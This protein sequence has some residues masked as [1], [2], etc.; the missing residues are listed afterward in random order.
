[1]TSAITLPLEL[2]Y[3]IF[4]FALRDEVTNPGTLLLVAKRVQSWL[5]PHVYLTVIIHPS[6]IYP[7]DMSLDAIKHHGH[8]TRHLFIQYE[9][10]DADQIIELL[11]HFPNVSNLALWHEEI[12]EEI[13]N[14]LNLANVTSLSIDLVQFKEVDLEKDDSEILAEYEDDPEL[15]QRL[16]NVKRK[17]LT[18]FSRV[19]HLVISGEV[20]YAED[21]A[22]LKYFTSLT[23]LGIPVVNAEALADVIQTCPRLE[24]VAFLGGREEEEKDICYFHE[25]VLGVVHDV[26][27]ELEE[28][29]AQV[30]GL[31]G[32]L[33]LVLSR[34]YLAGW[35]KGARGGEGIWAVAERGVR[36]KIHAEKSKRTP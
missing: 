16:V 7:P 8:H 18:F 28:I 5:I 11:P 24:L 36:E 19:T 21:M 32:K 31:T 27:I 23:H 30:E 33:V 13:E 17:G 14:I 2:E 1:M 35:E 4:M 15:Q 12:G 22:A 34:Q 6:R 25:D 26:D 9:P 10:E 20:E 29:E 3:E